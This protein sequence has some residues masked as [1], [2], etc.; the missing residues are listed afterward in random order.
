MKPGRARDGGKYSQGMGTPGLA[1]ARTK[2]R[3]QR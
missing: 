3:I 2:Y 1:Y